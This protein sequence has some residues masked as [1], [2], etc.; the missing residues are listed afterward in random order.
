MA[1]RCCVGYGGDRDM[2]PRATPY[3]RIEGML[4]S[5]QN[6]TAYGIDWALPHGSTS[7]RPSEC[8]PRR[9]R[10]TSRNSSSEIATE[11][12]RMRSWI[13]TGHGLLREKGVI[14]HNPT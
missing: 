3:A 1:V 7:L 11:C 14:V 2:G 13:D 8:W 12:R 6:L 5:C 10:F 4:F 9:R